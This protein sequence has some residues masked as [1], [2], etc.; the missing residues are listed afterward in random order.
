MWLIAPHDLLF[1]LHLHL[2]L[3]LH[4]HLQLHLHYLVNYGE[5]QSITVKKRSIT[6]KN[7]Q[8]RSKTLNFSQKGSITL[9]KVNYCQKR[10]ITVKHGQL[11]GGVTSPFLGLHARATDAPHQAMDE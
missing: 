6:V 4:L 1:H 9:K 7:A 2:C 8:L 10:S 3:I 5:K 11:G